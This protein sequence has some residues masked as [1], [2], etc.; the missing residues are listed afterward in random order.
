MLI[1]KVVEFELYSVWLSATAF[2]PNIY[3]KKTLQ[4]TNGC[5]KY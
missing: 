5:P 1:T 3:C 2:N 4:F